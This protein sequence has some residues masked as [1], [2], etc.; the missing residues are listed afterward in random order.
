MSKAKE[1]VP[2]VAF[3]SGPKLARRDGKDRAP[4]V[5]RR[6]A[7]PKAAPAAVSRGP[8]LNRGTTHM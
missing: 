8:T 6:M 5:R 1:N 3:G 2:P 4:V 7:K